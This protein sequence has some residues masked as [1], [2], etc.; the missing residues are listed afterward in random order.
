MSRHSRGS[1]FLARGFWY[2]LLG[3]TLLAGCGSRI[4]VQADA[5]DDACRTDAECGVGE[6]CR[7]GACANADEQPTTDGGSGGS[8]PT[9]TDG[10]SGGSRPTTI[11]GGSGGSEPT[12]IAG[13]ADG[14]EGPALKCVPNQPTC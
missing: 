7:R 9:T 13:S 3:L 10:G 2:Q 5:A 4:S 6:E 14:G 8:G 1:G 12:T 11:A